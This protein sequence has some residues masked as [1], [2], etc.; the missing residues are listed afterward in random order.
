MKNKLGN[1]TKWIDNFQVMRILEAGSE[2]AYG[3]LV[4][5]PDFKSGVGR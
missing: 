2:E 5:P 1:P 4:W 3:Y